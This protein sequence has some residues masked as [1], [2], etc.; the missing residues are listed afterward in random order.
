MAERRYGNWMQRSRNPRT[1]RMQRQNGNARQRARRKSPLLVSGISENTTINKQT[2]GER[3]RAREGRRERGRREDRKGRYAE[4]ARVHSRVP[5]LPRRESALC[6]PEDGRGDREWGQW[7][8]RSDYPRRGADACAPTE[9]PLL[10]TATN[11][12]DFFPS[13]GQIRT[14]TRRRANKQFRMFIRPRDSR[15]TSTGVPDR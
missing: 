7:R 14:R 6:E 11:R 15:P 12:M 3:E 10:L 4:C 9:I 1:D 2:H 5:Y 13:N 8:R